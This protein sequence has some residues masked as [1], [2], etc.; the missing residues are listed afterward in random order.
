[1]TRG[2]HIAATNAQLRPHRP[3]AN[4]SARATSFHAPGTHTRQS[5]HMPARVC[6]CTQTRACFQ[7][8]RV[9]AGAD[10][11]ACALLPCFVLCRTSRQDWI[12]GQNDWRVVQVRELALQ[13]VRWSWAVHRDVGMQVTGH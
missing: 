11:A 6:L 3:R 9:C 13:L 2:V 8:A 1:M 5:L 7:R 12:P 10:P 4:F